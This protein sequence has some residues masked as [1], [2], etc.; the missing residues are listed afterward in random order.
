MEYLPAVTAP[1]R[2]QILSGWGL[3]AGSLMA[4]AALGFV[5]VIAAVAGIS[6]FTRLLQHRSTLIDTSSQAVVDKIRQLSRLEAVDY[7]IDKIVE[8]DRQSPLLPNFLAGDRL[9]L[10]AHGE[11]IAGVDLSQL[12]GNAVR[13]EGDSVHVS[14]PPPQILVARLDNAQTRVYSR[15]TGLLVAADPNLESEARATAEQEITK[16]ALADGILDKA[17]QN[18][19]AE[20]TGLL[21]ALGFRKV[22]VQ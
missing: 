5:L 10:V 15:E 16:A 8:G 6:N 14:L 7:T 19:R 2:K 20:V 13:V 11:V 22:D 21:Y 9:L 1:R 4:G 17:R 18:A 3:V 12:R